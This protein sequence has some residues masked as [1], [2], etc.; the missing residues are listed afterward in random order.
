MFL[1]AAP[2]VPSVV[3]PPKVQSPDWQLLPQC[4]VLFP[5]QPLLEQQLP[6]GQSPQMVLLWSRPQ[7]PSVVLSSVRPLGEEL[8][9]CVYVVRVR[10]AYLPAPELK[11]TDH[12][13]VPPKHSLFAQDFFF[14]IVLASS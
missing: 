6:S 11:S 4:A 7:V 5:H 10:V 2:Q 9:M 14:A 3:S 8:G 13:I 1:K 12:A